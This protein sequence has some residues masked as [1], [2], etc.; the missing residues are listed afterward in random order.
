M[1]AKLATNKNSPK[2][3]NTAASNTLGTWFEHVENLMGTQ[4]WFP[5]THLFK[6]YEFNFGQRL[7]DKSLFDEV[8]KHLGKNNGN[9]RNKLGMHLEL[10]LNTLRTRKSQ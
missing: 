10:N 9:M 4:K 3:Q 2:K 5:L 8:R 1:I 7:C 6:Y